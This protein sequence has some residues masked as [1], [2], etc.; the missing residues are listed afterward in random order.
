MMFNTYIKQIIFRLIECVPRDDDECLKNTI[1]WGPKK[2]V[3]MQR[4]TAIP[5]LKTR[6]DAALKLVDLVC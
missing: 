2:I 3:H 1:N 4:N 5:G 6:E